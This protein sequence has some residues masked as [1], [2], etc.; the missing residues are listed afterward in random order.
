MKKATEKL[1]LFLIPCLFT[2]P[3]FKESISTFMIILLAANTLFYHFSHKTFPDLKLKNLLL[4]LPFWILFSYSM[5]SNQLFENQSHLQHALFFLIIPLCFLSIPNHFFDSEK[6]DLYF[7]VLKITSLLIC[8]F[9]I[10]SYFY[11][12]NFKE[13]FIV[14]Q[15]VSSFRNYIYDDL[16]IIKIHPTYF[17]SILVLCSTHAFERVIKQKKYFELLYIFVFLLISFLL[18]TKLNLIFLILVLLGMQ[19]FRSQFTFK[20]KMVL[21]AMLT[22]A[23]SL[24]V[25]L[26]PGIKSRFMEVINSANRP[27]QGVE[28]DSTNIRKAIFDCSISILKTDYLYGVGFANLQNKLND[29]Y[30]SNYDSSFYKETEYMTHN[31]FLYLFISSGIFGFACFLFYVMQVIK[32]ALKINNFVFNIFLINIFLMCCIED[33]L[34]RH[35]GIFFFQLILLCFIKASDFKT[36]EN[37]S[38][39]Q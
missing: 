21:T 15:N 19:L 16:K 1:F 35:Y 36:L 39:T 14:F 17:T 6:M 30:A 33:F 31:Y 25:F 38:I 11:Y 24:L 28:F 27:P 20:K 5:V 10:A 22:M 4:T 13:L 29:C 9:Y 12:H 23:I 32:I 18:I 37:K 7:S 26:T 34:F 2:F 8:V 3:L